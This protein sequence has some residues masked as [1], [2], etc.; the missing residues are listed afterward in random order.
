VINERRGFLTGP[1]SRLLRGPKGH[2]KN[3]VHPHQSIPLKFLEN[4]QIYRSTSQTILDVLQRRER[5]AQRTLNH[6]EFR[7]K[8][9]EN[10]IPTTKPQGPGAH[11]SSSPCRGQATRVMLQ[12]RR[13]VAVAVRASP[14]CCLYDLQ[15]LETCACPW[16]G[17]SGNGRCSR[18]QKQRALNQ[19]AS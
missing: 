18:R 2:R 8:L 16:E 1:C 5:Q 6:V 17:C 3:R 9:A 11:Q 12:S 10:K 7:Q 14:K 19:S 4:V 15:T 13:T